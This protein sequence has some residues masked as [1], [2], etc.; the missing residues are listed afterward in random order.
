MYR[1]LSS[2]ALLGLVAVTAGCAMC[3]HP[4]DECFPLFTGGCDGQPCGGPRAGTIRNPGDPVTG[5]MLAPGGQEMYYEEMVPAQAGP[6]MPMPARAARSQ[7]SMAPRQQRVAQ[8]RPQIDVR[9]VIPQGAQVLSVTDETLA[10]AQARA[11]GAEL[12][13]PRPA[14]VN[15]RTAQRPHGAATR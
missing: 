1:M 6:V 11:S 3:A 14:P 2:W 13:G 4:Y 7:R 8:A 10:E 9:Q 12:A 5:G 15:A